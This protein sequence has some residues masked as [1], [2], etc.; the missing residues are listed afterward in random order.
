MA[1]I[2]EDLFEEYPE[3]YEGCKKFLEIQANKLH[4]F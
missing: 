4:C 3:H 2:S 1:A